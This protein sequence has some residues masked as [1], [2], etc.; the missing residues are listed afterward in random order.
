MKNPQT[1]ILQLMIRDID[2]WASSMNEFL[3]KNGIQTE[4][5]SLYNLMEAVKKLK[6]R[7]L[8]TNYSALVTDENGYIIRAYQM[9]DFV[10]SDKVPLDVTGGYYK[11]VNNEFILDEERQRQMDE[12]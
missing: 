5:K 1:D 4:S 10:E 3:I 6:V 7:L 12:V 8:D 2:S 11:F 9:H